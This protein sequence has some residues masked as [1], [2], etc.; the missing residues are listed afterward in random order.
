[1][2]AYRINSYIN[3]DQLKLKYGLKKIEI[4]VKKDIVDYNWLLEEE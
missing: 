2:P 4:L 3:F 1:M